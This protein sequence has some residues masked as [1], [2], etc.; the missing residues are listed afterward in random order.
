M[1]ISRTPFRISFFGGG[2][3]YPV[4][5]EEN[6]GAVLS[7]TIDKYCYIICRYLP[8]FFDHKT[9]V[10]WSKIEL[11]G[12]TDE[13]E[14]PTA[15]ESLKHLGIEE[16]ME[17]HHHGDLPAR[18]GLG[19][20]SAFTVGLL[21]ALYSLQNRP[22][23]KEK[24]AQEAIYV[25][26]DRVK[27]NI[28]SQDQIATAFGGFNRVEFFPGRKFQVSP[29]K[30][31]PERM[32][33]LQNHLMLFFT[34]LSRTA[35]GVAEVQIK[36]TPRNGRELHRMRRMVDEAMEIL[37]GP[38]QDFDDFGRLLHDAWMLKRGLSDVITNS[39]IDQIYEMG[40]SEGAL[41]GKI[42][43]A[44]GGG[45]MLFFVRPEDQP[46]VREKLKDL[47]EVPFQFESEGSRIIY[48]S[49]NDET[50]DSHVMPS[51]LKIKKDAPSL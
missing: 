45:F 37:D 50:R 5:T 44:G 41:G 15:R 24:L 12:G 49:R 38:D 1:I 29:V 48:D 19:S 23:S 32:E 6:G 27:E 30:M 20:S 17:I 43:G 13:I 4:W 47:L 9:R 26:Q 31:A 25:E 22:V 18:G 21:N 8:P 3:D 14:H 10:V 51:K 28:G 34:G 16:G 35:S 33:K 40:L 7:T 42:L 2:T 11:V 39:R 36:N 46:R